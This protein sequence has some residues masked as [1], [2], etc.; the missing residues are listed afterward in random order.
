MCDDGLGYVHA[1]GLN[2]VSTRAKKK[3]KWLANFV[4]DDGVVAS[5]IRGGKLSKRK[6]R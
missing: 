2:S 3:S 1:Y 6:G 5:A 4:Q